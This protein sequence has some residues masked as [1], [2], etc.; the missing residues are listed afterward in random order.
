MPS[1]TKAL[2][3]LW[4]TYRQTR[5]VSVR[6]QLALEYNPYVLAFLRKQH[7]PSNLLND[8]TQDLMVRLLTAIEQYDGRGSFSGFLWKELYFQVQDSYRK[9]AGAL[10]P[11]YGHKLRKLAI[12]QRSQGRQ[13]TIEDIMS[14]CNTGR[15]KAVFLASAISGSLRSFMPRSYH[16]KTRIPAIVLERLARLPKRLAGVLHMY[17]I[18]NLSIKLIGCILNIAERSVYVYL[19]EARRCM[20]KAFGVEE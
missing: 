11:R 7:V 1:D 18:D 13:V 2:T 17:Y 5:D 20:R 14:F 19:T 16:V 12:K 4:E 10:S 6:N 9:Y 3:K 15:M 8:I